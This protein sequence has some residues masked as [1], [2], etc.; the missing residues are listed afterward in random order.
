MEHCFLGPFRW[1]VPVLYSLLE[2]LIEETLSY[3]K[4]NSPQLKLDCC[5]LRK[6]ISKTKDTPVIIYSHFENRSSGP[7]TNP[8]HIN[9]G[10]NPK[11]LHVSGHL[12]CL[13]MLYKLF[14]GMSLRVIA[15][16]LDI[17]PYT[18]ITFDN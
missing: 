8:R 15:N 14:Y 7:P 10:V 9:A 13:I 17:S 3:D 1:T 16:K 2:R 11:S 12:K 5:Q 6:E 4:T 18:S